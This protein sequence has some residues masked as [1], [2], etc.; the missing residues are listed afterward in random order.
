MQEERLLARVWQ[1]GVEAPG[2]VVQQTVTQWQARAAAY[3]RN[4]FLLAYTTLIDNTL[5]ALLQALRLDALFKR[6]TPSLEDGLARLTGKR[7]MQWPMPA[8]YCHLADKDRNKWCHAGSA[9]C[10]SVVDAGAG[11]ITFVSRMPGCVQ[12]AGPEGTKRRF[13]ESHHAC[14][15]LM[16]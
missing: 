2:Q 4:S 5:V 14:I 9:L 10:G 13:G 6:A 16:P 1:G 7:T 8:F 3:A 11:S 12:T 15:L